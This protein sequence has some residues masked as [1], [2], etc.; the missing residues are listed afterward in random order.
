MFPVT[1]TADHV[2]WLALLV[3]HQGGVVTYRGTYLDDGRPLP[4]LLFPELLVDVLVAEGLLAVA[5]LDDQGRARVSLAETGSARLAQLCQQLAPRPMPSI[6]P[7]S[8]LA[9]RRHC[10]DPRVRPARIRPSTR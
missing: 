6:P 7:A 4:R 1:L 10:Q 8:G 5:Q 9:V 3:V 2:D